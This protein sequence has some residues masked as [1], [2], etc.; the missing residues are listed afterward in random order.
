MFE[1]TKKQA[2]LQRFTLRQYIVS[3]SR[4]FGEIRTL[5]CTRS[6]FSLVLGLSAAGNLEKGLAISPPGL[7]D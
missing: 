7:G 1:P 5:S 2:V 3:M 6:R 4:T